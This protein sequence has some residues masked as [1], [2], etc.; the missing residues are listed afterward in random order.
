MIWSVAAERF[1]RMSGNRK[2]ERR[3]PAAQP[4]PMGDSAA[5]QVAQASGPCDGARPLEPA[6][7]GQWAYLKYV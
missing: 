2:P 4:P 6:W 7:P 1:N 5:G 3:Y